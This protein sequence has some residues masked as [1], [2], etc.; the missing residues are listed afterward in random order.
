[1]GLLCALT[2][3]RWLLGKIFRVLVAFLPQAGNHARLMPTV[4]DADAWGR[5]DSRIFLPEIRDF[6]KICDQSQRSAAAAVGSGGC[7]R[8]PWGRGSGVAGKTGTGR[9]FSARNQG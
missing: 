9:D 6:A 8:M 4:P 5:W 3:K 7:R 1:M 2:I